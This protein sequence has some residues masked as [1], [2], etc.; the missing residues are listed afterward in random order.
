MAVCLVQP[1]KGS[2]QVSHF[3]PALISIFHLW[4]FP[5]K[6]TLIF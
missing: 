6:E 4:D 2:C 1:G 5:G 3:P